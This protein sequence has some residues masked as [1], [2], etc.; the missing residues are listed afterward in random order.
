[1]EEARALRVATQ[2]HNYPQGEHVCPAA[3]ASRWTLSPAH[4]QGVSTFRELDSIPPVLGPT[5][6]DAV[7]RQALAAEQHKHMHASSKHTH[8]A[9]SEKP[10]SR[11]SHI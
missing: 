2:P 4:V 10:S 11:K 8:E 1:M 7:V 6:R 3:T 5:M 9:V